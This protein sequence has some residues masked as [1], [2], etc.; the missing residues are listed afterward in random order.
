METSCQTEPLAGTTELC[1]PQ[2]PAKMDFHCK[3][4]AGQ[5]SLV[6]DKFNVYHFSCLQR[7][8]F[9]GAQNIWGRL[10][11]V[12]SAI[13]IAQHALELFLLTVCTL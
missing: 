10:C 9:S 4:S 12:N 6:C 5:L 7:E 11:N 2:Y 13:H 1:A 8:L 3:I